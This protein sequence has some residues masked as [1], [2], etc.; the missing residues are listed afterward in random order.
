MRFRYLISSAVLAVVLVGSTTELSAHGTGPGNSS[1]GMIVTRHFSGVWDQVDQEAQGLALQVVEQ[2]D[3]SR[4]SVVYWYTYGVDRKTAW[5]IGIGDLVENRIDFELFESTDVG[6]MQ[7]TRPGNDSVNSI[8][9]MTIIFDNCDS[10]I[11]TFDTDNEEVGSGTFNIERLLEIM[12]THCSG[13]I[14]DDMHADS[15]FGDQYL[16]LMPARQD[17]SGQGLAKYEDYPGHM[18]FEVRVDGLPDGHYHLLV[19]MMDRG[20]FVVLDGHGKIEFSSPAE[21]GHMM[22]TFDPRGEQIDVQD[23]QGAVLSSF[24]DMFE[25][26]EHGHHGNDEDHDG[27]EDHNFDCE[28]GPGSGHGTGHGTGH[29]MNDGM[30]DCVD[31]GNFIDIEMDLENTGILPVAKGEAEWEMNTHRVEFSVEIED[32]P[33]GSYPLHVG[34]NEV[35]TIDA[36]AMHNGN[37]HGHIKFRDPEV[38]GREHLDFEARGQKIEVFQGEQIILEV[39]FPTE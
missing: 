18:E 9:T 37:V 16:Q 15:L 11:V 36:F 2:F 25:E 38:S 13:G 1:D 28:F 33:V 31:D 7:D 14:S 8:G 32:V 24:D 39:E 23:N 22:L 5:F 3:D 4:K 30:A 12:N 27:E 17:I 26:D 35:G 34:G 21:D 10:G 29:G 20:E 6:F 19:G